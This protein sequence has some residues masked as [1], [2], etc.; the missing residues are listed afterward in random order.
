MTPENEKSAAGPRRDLSRR[1]FLAAAGAAMAAPIVVDP[2]FAA[3][4]VHLLGRETLKVG[5][6]GCGGRGTGAAIQ[7]LRA[8]KGAVLWAVADLLEDRIKGSLAGI[9]EELGEQAAGK[10]DVGDRKFLGFDAYKSLIASG[11]DV[12][13]LCTVPAFRPAHL[14]EAVRAGKHVFCEKPM[15]VDAPGLARVRAAAREAKAKGLSLTSGFCWRYHDAMR[16]TFGKIHEG[17]LGDVLSVH[18]TYHTSTLSARPRKP[19]WS[20]MEFQLRNWWHFTWLS[21]DHIVEQACHS[22]DRLAWALNDAVP[23]SCTALG[24]RAAREGET[25]GHVFDHF[26][27]IYEYANGLRAHH[28][29]RQIDHCPNDNRD[30]VYG[31]K[32]WSVVNGWAPPWE[33]KD[34]SGK[35]TWRYDGP[36]RDM[37][38]NEHDHFFASIRAKSA[39]NDGEWMCN[40]VQM[41]LMGRMAAYT[42]QT[43]T[44][45]QCTNS[46]EDLSPAKLEFGPMPQ[47]PVA[48]PGKTKFI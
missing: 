4:A 29:C 12:V 40:S 36:V 8:D 7:A 23:I 41:A 26:A 48:V 5:L 43:V 10:I 45:D 42:G 18:T 15:A 25:S 46:R 11:V 39:V 20:E 33:I 35:T 32:G 34:L 17:A 38:Q 31:T 24:G 1:S 47:P 16:A 9:E 13:L 3:R 19:E 30:Y 37:Y 14:E 6:V 22:I 21:G 44:W 27:V 28:T 2:E